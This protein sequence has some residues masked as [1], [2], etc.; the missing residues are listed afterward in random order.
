MR[1]G[2]PLL[3]EQTLAV[4]QRLLLE[5]WRQRRGLIF[6]AAFP[7]AM[8]LLFGLVYAH[9]ASM[10]AGLDAAAAGIL[11]G[12]A[13]FFSCLGGTVALIAAERERRTLRRLLASPLHPVAYFLG[14]VL[15]QLL[16]ACVQV[17]VLYSI[18]WFIGAR[19]HGSLWLG[20]LI[21]LL[22]VFSYVGMGFFLGARFARRSEEVV[23]ALSAIGVPLLVLG[24]TF[25]PLEIMPSAMQA[26]AQFNPMLH[27][28]QAFKGVAAYG[29]GVAELRFE[30][31]FLVLF[32]G[33]SLGLGVRSYRQ[34][35]LLE[36]RA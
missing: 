23:V 35:L 13:L 33:L 18:A 15:A 20:G 25:F 9:N 24:G 2:R 21:L 28:N 12:A 11:M 17:V 19:Y 34:L 31:G 10:R 6:W 30:L 7:A 32:C 4:A 5:Q 22:S 8:M 14:V 26:V 1:P 16:L 3:L 36:Q 27:M 29:L